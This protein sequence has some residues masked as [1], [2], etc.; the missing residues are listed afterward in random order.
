MEATTELLLQLSR[1]FAL[2]KLSLIKWQWAGSLEERRGDLQAMQIRQ[3][4]TIM[5]KIRKLSSQASRAGLLRKQL[6][7]NLVFVSCCSGLER[8]RHRH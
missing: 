3:F 5:Q 6:Y 8:H 4:G 2:P 1:I 7:V